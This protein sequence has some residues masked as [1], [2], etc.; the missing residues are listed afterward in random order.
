MNKYG[1]GFFLFCVLLVACQ[2][3]KEIVQFEVHESGQAGDGQ[4][5]AKI[6]ELRVAYNLPAIGAMLIEGNNILE[7]DQL[8]LS[9][10]G[11]T[12]C[13][14]IVVFSLSCLFQFS[15]Q[16]QLVALSVGSSILDQSAAG[17]LLEWQL[18]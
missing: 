10:S 12:A 17:S 1:F 18:S 6:E 9:H 5:T 13:A 15:Y 11:K 2:K 16:P 7:M 3:D 4:L 8:G 14:D